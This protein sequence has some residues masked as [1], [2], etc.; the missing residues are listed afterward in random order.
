MAPAEDTSDR[1]DDAD[2]ARARWLH[3]T[4]HR[5]AHQYYVL[6]DPLIQANTPAYDFNA[7]GTVDVSDVQ[8][9]NSRL[10]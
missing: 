7:D 8:K 10:Q 1:P 9:L 5:H 2:A 6:D 3:E 4:L